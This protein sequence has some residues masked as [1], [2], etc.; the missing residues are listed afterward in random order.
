M[1]KIGAI[2]LIHQMMIVVPWVPAAMTK[3]EIVLA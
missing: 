3:K 1:T 2:R